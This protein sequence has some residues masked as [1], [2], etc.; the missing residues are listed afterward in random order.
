[1]KKIDDTRN[2]DLPFTYD[3]TSL[4]GQAMRATRLED[5]GDREKAGRMWT[6]LAEQADKEPDKREWYLLAC[7]QRALA[8]TGKQTNN[9]LN[10]R[11]ELLQTRMA[12]AEKTAALVKE[13]DAH[14][15]RYRAD[16]R[17]KCREIID[18]YEEEPNDIIT[19]LVK[20]AR[21]LSASVSKR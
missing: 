20:K 16:V 10:D 17:K 4:E 1:R 21:T 3:A 19:G 9:S 15:N 11:I 14:E 18:L 6:Q 12:E 7:Q 8:N 13:G 2:N 5:I